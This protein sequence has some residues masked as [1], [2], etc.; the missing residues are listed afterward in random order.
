LHIRKRLVEDVKRHASYQGDVGVSALE[1]HQQFGIELR[2]LRAG[3]CGEDSIG[4]LGL[5][6]DEQPRGRACGVVGGCPGG[7]ARLDAVPSARF[8]M[9]SSKGLSFA[10]GSSS[11]VSISSS[12]AG[13]TDMARHNE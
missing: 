5:T 2:A 8:V 7:I 12:L 9:N 3:V 4:T 1:H 6:K 10:G 13:R 11:A